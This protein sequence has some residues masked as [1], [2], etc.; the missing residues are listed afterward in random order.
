[1]TR[2]VLLN[3]VDHK[4]LRIITRRAHA[5]GDGV[6]YAPTFPAEF[7]TIQG[8]YPI[9]F[10]KR[11]DTGQFQPLALLGLEEGENLF[12]AGHGWDANYIPMSV[13]RLPFF[14]GG[15]RS[16]EAGGA[17]RRVIHI[18]L[19]H[20]RVSESEGERLFRE[21][22]GT[23]EF[24]DRMNGLLDQ[25]DQGMQATAAF[26]EALLAHELLESFVLDITLKDGSEG[27]LAGF[28][29]INEER[30]RALGST[31]VGALHAQGMLE[32]IYMVV[33]SMAHLRDL[34]DRRNR[35]H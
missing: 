3:N 29:T 7:R 9:V 4:A 33:A 8:N 13:E 24:L 21:Y 34:I 19:D 17:P 28:Y 22:G 23:T 32:P 14:I 26:I 10:Q 16:S 5:Y 6:M 30:L 15:Q 31:A 2:L 18:D 1:M 35:R 20:P 11:G 27:R 12:L 25:L